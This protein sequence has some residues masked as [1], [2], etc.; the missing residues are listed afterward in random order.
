M[1]SE[2]TTLLQTMNTAIINPSVIC[3]IIT[4]ISVDMS[5]NQKEKQRFRCANIYY[6]RCVVF[7]L[8][9]LMKQLHVNVHLKACT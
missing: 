1:K 2:Y 4:I 6:L 5:L 9:L 7:S 3:F 8:T